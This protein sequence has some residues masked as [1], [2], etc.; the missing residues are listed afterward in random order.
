MEA[1][2]A[3]QEI[4]MPA[5]G[6]TTSFFLFCLAM[7]CMIYM[8]TDI[9]KISCLISYKHTISIFFGI[10]KHYV[11][12]YIHMIMIIYVRIYT[13]VCVCICMKYIQCTALQD[14]AKKK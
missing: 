2:S 8:L 12:I 4:E 10:S 7:N 11:Y 1:G 5:G 9:L 6:G 3:D 14:P 13:S